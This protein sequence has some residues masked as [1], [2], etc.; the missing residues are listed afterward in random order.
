MFKTKEGHPVSFV[1][2]RLGAL[3]QCFFAGLKSDYDP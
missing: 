1:K 2:R 3:L